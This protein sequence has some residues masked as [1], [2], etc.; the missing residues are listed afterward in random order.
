[1]LLAKTF[2]FKAA[3]VK[4]ISSYAWKKSKDKLPKFQKWFSS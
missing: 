1:M 4:I 3:Y 2:S